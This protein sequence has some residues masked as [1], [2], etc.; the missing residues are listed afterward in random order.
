MAV[1]GQVGSIRGVV[2]ERDGDV[3]LGGGPLAEHIHRH[4]LG[5]GANEGGRKGKLAA[6]GQRAEVPPHSHRAH[7]AFFRCRFGPRALGAPAAL[8]GK[9]GID[10][11]RAVARQTTFESEIV[12]SA[13]A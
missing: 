2:A 7:Q 9:S 1:G 4:L 5:E 8:R 12:F 13:A 3:R 6:V 10:D 11:A